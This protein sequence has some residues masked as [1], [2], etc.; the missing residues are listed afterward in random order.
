M[1]PRIDEL[2]TLEDR[3]PVDASV[4]S[5]VNQ[6][7]ECA[8]SLDRLIQTRD[9]L[10]NLPLLDAPDAAWQRIQTA[11]DDSS[12]PDSDSHKTGRDR[13]RAIA[14]F[15]VAA[16]A[17]VVALLLVTRVG[18]EPTE[19]APR[20]TPT[21]E[22]VA[23]QTNDTMAQLIEQS[24]ELDALLQALPERPRVERVAMAA[25]LDTIEDRI[26]WLDFQLSSGD[27]ELDE[28]QGNRLWRERVE[29]MDS[30][31][32]VRYAQTGSASF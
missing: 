9:A 4:A 12:K 18:N 25:T 3:T 19:P 20:I 13:R 32:K 17:A 24:R 5:H 30:L 2:L 7:S 15:A 26:Q 22:P 28:T 11:L 31:V 6:C 8:A 16:S 27:G 1:H 21:V 10:R 14:A 29:L 23:P